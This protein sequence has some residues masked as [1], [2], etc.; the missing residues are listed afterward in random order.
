MTR[1]KKPQKAVVNGRVITLSDGREVGLYMLGPSTFGWR[2]VNKAGDVT[3][4][5]LSREAMNAM[6][7]LHNEVTWQ[8]W[9]VSPETVIG[10]IG[11]MPSQCGG[12]VSRN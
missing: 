3:Q 8:P 12:D 4:F 7:A 9:A 2:L 6:L 5:S 1:K 10:G 11:P